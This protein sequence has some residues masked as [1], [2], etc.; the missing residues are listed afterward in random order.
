MLLDAQSLDALRAQPEPQFAER[1]TSVIKRDLTARFEELSGRRLY[2]AQVE[3]FIIDL[4]SYALGNVGGAIQAGL[5]QNRAIWAEGEHLEQLGAN[6]GTHRLDATSAHCEVTFTLSELR[7]TVVVVPLGTRVA[8]GSNLVFS[9]VQELVIPAGQLTGSVTARATVAGV[10]H[11]DLQP[12]QVQDILD[13][14]AYVSGVSN[15]GISAGGADTES[16]DRFRL[17]VV[18]A[19][20][21]ITRGG[22]RAGYVELVM[23]A[24]PDIVDVA[25]HRPQPGYIDIF[26]LVSGGTAPDAIDDIIVAYL[27]P[28]TRVPMGD[29]V[30]VKKVAAEVFDVTVTLKMATGY[31]SGAADKAE[32]LIRVLFAGWS[33]KLGA[34]IA[35]SAIVE[36]VRAVPGVVGIDGPGF[37]F[38]DLPA[39][40]FAALGTLTVTV[41]EAPNV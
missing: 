40:S 33:Q 18:N 26:P 16:D 9:T 8:A 29:L 35:P 21:R 41:E 23:A 32:A 10:S 7:N 19:L 13:P 1:D 3:S 31:L 22:S 20:E 2:P 36:A 28:E 27:D 17:R 14:V 24:H 30:T 39:A 15:S 6:V 37:V 11:N 12:G 5:L 34:Q 38:T 25:V 4:M